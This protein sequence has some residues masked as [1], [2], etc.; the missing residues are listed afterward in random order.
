VLVDVRQAAFASGRRSV[1]EEV[2]G[3]FRDEFV[4]D[5]VV[6]PR[7]PSLP[8]LLKHEGT[9]LQ[10]SALGFLVGRKPLRPTTSLL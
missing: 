10:T 5:H 6:R 9:E 8:S 2:L 3:G 7:Q 1:T 4:R